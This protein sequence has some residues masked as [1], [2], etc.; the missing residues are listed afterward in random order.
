[1]AK[2][3]EHFEPLLCF[4]KPCLLLIIRFLLELLDAMQYLFKGFLRVNE[5][6]PLAVAQDEVVSGLAA[7]DLALT[8]AESAEESFQVIVRAIALGPG[9]TSEQAWPAL[10]Q[11]SLDMRDHRGVFRMASGVLGQLGQKGFYL[12]LDL[13]PR[14]TRLSLANGRIEAS[15]QFDQP[16]PLTPELAIARGERTPYLNHSQQLIQ[17]RMPPF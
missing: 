4:E 5:N 10:F 3:I 2:T 16:V 13:T 8:R 14:R 11:R 15:F 9:V 7:I 12:L 6:R 1:V 17:E